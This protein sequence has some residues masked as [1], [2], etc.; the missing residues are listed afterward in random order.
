MSVNSRMDK[1]D[2]VWV[3]KVECY[4]AMRKKEIVPRVSTG[5]DLEGMLSD[6]SQ[7]KT[8][9]MWYHLY[10]RHLKKKEE[11]EESS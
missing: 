6:V 5:L 11:E 1:E 8:N 7:T 3:L 2:V 9:A 10:I 4:S